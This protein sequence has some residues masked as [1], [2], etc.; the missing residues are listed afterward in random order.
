M[1]ISS[2]P[3]VSIFF[4][5][6]ALKMLSHPMNELKLRASRRLITRVTRYKAA[7]SKLKGNGFS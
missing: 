4:V 1:I 2:D 3:S 7:K 5:S 6:V